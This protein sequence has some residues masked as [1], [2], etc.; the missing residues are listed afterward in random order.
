MKYPFVNFAVLSNSDP[1]PP[2]KLSRHIRRTFSALQTAR[3]ESLINAP[4]VAPWG[5]QMM[6]LAVKKQGQ[7]QH[8]ID[9]FLS[10]VDDKSE[11]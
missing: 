7:H 10:V 8:V 6:V 5:C 4:S 9:M 2:K 11:L 3:M 1:F